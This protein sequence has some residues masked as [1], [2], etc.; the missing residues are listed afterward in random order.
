M[1]KSFYE[2]C[3]PDVRAAADRF[4]WNLKNG[5]FRSRYVEEELGVKYKTPQQIEKERIENK[6]W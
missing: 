5:Y 4:I 1:S 6:P 2:S 3:D